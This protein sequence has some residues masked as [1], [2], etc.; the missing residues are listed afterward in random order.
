M[1]PGMEAARSPHISG[2]RQRPLSAELVLHHLRPMVALIDET[3]EF[4]DAWGAH[5]AF[6]GYRPGDLIGRQSLDFVVPREQE[7]VASVFRQAAERSDFSVDMPVPFQL[8]LVA[9]N[10]GTSLVDVSATAVTNEPG[11]RGWV[12]TFV[13]HAARSAPVDAMELLLRGGTVD[14]V[15]ERC[16]DALVGDRTDSRHLV[17]CVLS[18][19]ENGRFTRVHGRCISAAMVAAVTEQIAEPTAPWVGLLPR[20]TS[21]FSLEEVPWP[22]AIAAAAEE[23]EAM[24]VVPVEVA[25]SC[26][27]VLLGFLA[28]LRRPL[29]GFVAQLFD[30]LAGTMALALEHQ[31]AQEDLRRAARLDG[32]TGVA[33]R[34]EFDEVLLG[35]ESSDLTV[36]YIDLD[37][38]KAVNDVYGHECGDRVLVEVARRI[39]EASGPDGIVAR[40]GGDEFALVLFGVSREVA[41]RTGE[42]VLAAVSAPLPADHGVDFVTVSV[43][44]AVGDEVTRVRDILAAADRALFDAKRTGRSRLALAE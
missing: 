25:G 21:L 30:R 13:P 33:N 39:V 42:R 38:F 4:V 17:G 31:R 40:L 26:E 6:L 41:R 43:G 12:L 1:L 15:F 19:P 16:A 18:H 22:L 24:V 7:M 5:G 37:E 2:A 3:G 20:A 34:T 14:D 23:F 36:L 11:F 8:T 27:A 10:G 32:L 28:P 29:P 35:S 9:A 44:I